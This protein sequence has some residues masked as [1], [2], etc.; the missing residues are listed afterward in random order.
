MKL[1]IERRYHGVIGWGGINWETGIDIYTLLHIKYI[2]N[3]DLLNST[4]NS[5]GEFPYNALHGKKIFKKKGYMYMY[6]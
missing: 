6:N 2:T 5:V 1:K 3:K 4:G